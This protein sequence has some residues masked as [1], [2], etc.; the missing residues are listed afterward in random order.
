MG[1]VI[2]LAGLAGAIVASVALALWMEWLSLRGLMLL[3]PARP[4]DSGS[5][6]TQQGSGR[7]S[8]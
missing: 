7:R 6:E 3:M 8:G 4:D 2:D 1:N 5:A